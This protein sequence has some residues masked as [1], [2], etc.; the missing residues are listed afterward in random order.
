MRNR[1]IMVQEVKASH[2]LVESKAEAQRLIAQIK[3][4]ESFENLARK[5]SKCPSGRSG[6]DL[7][8]FTRGKMVPAF[9]NAAFTLGKGQ[10]SEPIKTQFGYHIIKVTDVK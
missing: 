6:G 2:I 1:D 8:F 9:E 3:G 4:G 7:G 10:V 5:H